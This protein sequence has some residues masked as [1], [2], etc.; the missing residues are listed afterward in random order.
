MNAQNCHWPP[1]SPEVEQQ[2]Q[3]LF[4]YIGGEAVCAG[5]LSAVSGD[6]C[7]SRVSYG[8][9]AAWPAACFVDLF[10]QLFRRNTSVALA[11]PAFEQVHWWVF[12]GVEPRNNPAGTT[13]AAAARFAERQRQRHLGRDWELGADA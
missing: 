4:V 8:A 2:L 13:Q 9:A 6:G 7:L 11:D 5:E 12:A 10:E 3:K 1:D